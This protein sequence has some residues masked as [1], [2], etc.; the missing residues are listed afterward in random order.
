MVRGVNSDADARR[1]ERVAATEQR[2][3]DAATRLFL[4]HGYAGTTLAAVAAEADVAPRTVYVRFG[5]KSALFR[6][7]VDVAV[8]GDTAPVDVAHRDWTQRSLTAP[9][10][11][12]RMQAAAGAARDIMSRLGPLL[13]VA[14]QAAAV[15]PEIAGAWQA[16]RAD[17]CDQVRQ[18]WST[19]AQDGLLPAGVDVHW[20]GDTAAIL[21]AA[22][23]YL[24]INRTLGWGPDEYERW[25]LTTW[26]RLIGSMD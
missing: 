14:E 16:A 1:A 8:V 2:L 12:E 18:F 9:T 23:T 24:H 7:T 11:E 20:L 10:L 15:E 13:P 3:V 19:A 21:S 26:R 6:R 22:D 25:L 5:T 4:R 17:T